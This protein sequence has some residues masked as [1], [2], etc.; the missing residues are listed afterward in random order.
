[1]DHVED[2]LG[3]FNEFLIFLLRFLALFGCCE[4]IVPDLFFLGFGVL[5]MKRENDFLN[6]KGFQVPESWDFSAEQELGFS[7]QFRL[8]FEHIIRRELGLDEPM[9]IL[10]PGE[11]DFGKLGR[12]KERGNSNEL[13][14]AE[15][16]VIFLTVFIDEF[17]G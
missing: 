3:E 7:E 8:H 4:T 13:V 1:M 2:V 16:E 12:H 5:G 9:I 15:R 14:F 6:G 11:L 10:E 17:D